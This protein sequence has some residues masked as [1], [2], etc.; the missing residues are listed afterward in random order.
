MKKSIF[1]TL[2]FLIAFSSLETSAQTF[3]SGTP[4]AEDIAV[5]SAVEHAVCQKTGGYVFT[6]AADAVGAKLPQT[7]AGHQIHYCRCPQ[8]QI[9]HF[10][11]GGC[12]KRGVGS[13][14]QTNQPAKRVN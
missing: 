11:S 4:T 10:P 3:V 5:V 2:G 12:V 6:A 1:A 9:Y 8:G 13:L 7:V 14:P